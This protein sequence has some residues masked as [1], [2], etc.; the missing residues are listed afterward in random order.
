MKITVF[1]RCWGYRQCAASSVYQSIPGSRC[2]PKLGR[3]LPEP[4]RLGKLVRWTGQQL[5]DFA[6]PP[7]SPFPQKSDGS[8]SRVDANDRT[9]LR[10]R[11]G[12]ENGYP[13]PAKLRLVSGSRATGNGGAE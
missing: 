12:F 7:P 9:P 11:E 3:Q 10:E 4:I 6:T 13:V 1:C 5:I 8:E 2:R